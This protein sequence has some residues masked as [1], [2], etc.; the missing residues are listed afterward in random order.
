MEN[1][2]REK[3][4]QWF[5]EYTN[6]YPNSGSFRDFLKKEGI[7]LIPKSFMDELEGL[8]KEWKESADRKIEVGMLG[9]ST[10]LECADQLQKLIDSKTIKPK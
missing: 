5:Y 1:S 3:L 9:S 2:V 7:L 8:V 4:D 6:S 10:Q